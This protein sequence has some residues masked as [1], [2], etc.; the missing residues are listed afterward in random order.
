[1]HQL[2]R[3]QSQRNQYFGTFFFRNRA[4]LSLMCHLLDSKPHGAKLDISV[5]ACSKGAEVYSIMWAIRSARPDLNLNMR[6]VDISQEILDFAKKGVYSCVGLD[7]SNAL[8]NGVCEDRKNIIRNT[9]RDQNAPIFARMS[10]EELKT[11]C[12]VK[13]D[14]ASIKPEL[15]EG[16]VWLAGDANDPALIRILGPQDI[17]VANRFLC[18]MDPAVAEKCLRSFVRLVKPGGYLFVSGI[19]LDVRTRVARSLGWKPVKEMMREL[20]EGDA[21]LTQGWPLN[22]WGLEPF[23]TGRP[24]RDIRYASVFQI[25]RPVELVSSSEGER[26]LQGSPLFR[27]IQQ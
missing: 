2:V 26:H 12:D 8:C 17:V 6:A 14:E 4:E 7:E 19:D 22:Y 16:I 18:H 20:H 24:D 10:E 11:I 27:A 9:C 13:G 15:R 5:L 1:V 3:L 21:S 23:C 25:P